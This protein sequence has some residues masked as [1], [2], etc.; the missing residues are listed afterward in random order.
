MAIF[1]LPW[2]LFLLGTIVFLA[3]MVLGIAGFGGGT[4][5]DASPATARLAVAGAGIAVLGAL[6][7][8]FLPSFRPAI[9]AWYRQTHIGDADPPRWFVRACEALFVGGSALTLFE[10]ATHWP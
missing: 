6:I 7:W 2:V 3:A 8:A 9:R 10:I 5:H 1:R 4:I